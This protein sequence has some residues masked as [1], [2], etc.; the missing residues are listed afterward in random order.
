MSMTTI[1]EIKDAVRET[2]RECQLLDP[3]TSG[4]LPP[5]SDQQAERRIVT[6]LLDGTPLSQLD[7]LEPRWFYHPLHMVLLTQWQRVI[8]GPGVVD[9]ARAAAVLEQDGHKGPLRAYLEIMRDNTPFLGLDALRED[10]KTL[11][12]MWYRRSIVGELQTILSRLR[13]GT[14]TAHDALTQL[15]LIG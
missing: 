4:Q 1:K 11:R 6:A 9:L 15:H 12:E 10:C 7:P 14:L 3:L 13:S 2:I 5:P 8:D